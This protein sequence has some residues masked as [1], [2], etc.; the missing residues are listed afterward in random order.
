MYA[1][2][3]GVN[4]R[5]AFQRPANFLWVEYSQNSRARYLQPRNS[6]G[7]SNLTLSSHGWGHYE[8]VAL[9]KIF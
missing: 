7:N 9:G 6:E 4:L 5:D 1:T 2:L 3:V 8:T